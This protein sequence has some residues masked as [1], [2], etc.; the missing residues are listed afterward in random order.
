MATGKI[1]VV[2]GGSAGLGLSIAQTLHRDGF[3]VSVLGRG[4]ERMAQLVGRG[5]HTYI[6]DVSDA[7]AVRRTADEIL[8]SFGAVDVLVNNAGV[9]RTGMFLDT[10]DEDAQFQI[11]VNIIGVLNATKAFGQAL[12]ERRGTIINI[13]SALARLPLEGAAVYAA[14]KGAIESFTRA[15]ARELGP[16]GVRVNAIAPGL[17]RS[18]IYI[19]D[20]FPAD[21]YTEMLAGFAKKYVLGRH[22]EP[23]DVAELVSFLASERA[24]WI[25]GGIFPADGGYSAFGFRDDIPG[26]EK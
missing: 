13:S 22:G 16:A 12:C 17:V 25:T 21:S 14:T 11:N 18:E 19:A 26:Q 2:T 24:S 6:C 23:E 4:R 1:A 20:G 9:I 15:I 3:V 7:A 8:H 10:V 5:L